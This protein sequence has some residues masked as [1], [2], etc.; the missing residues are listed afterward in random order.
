MHFRKRDA[1]PRFLL[2]ILLLI[3]VSSCAFQRQLATD[4][5]ILRKMDA[6]LRS[7]LSSKRTARQLDRNV[8][9]IVTYSSEVTSEDRLGLRAIC[10]IGTIVGQFATVTIRP[11]RIIQLATIDRVIH[12][13][14][15]SVQDM[16]PIPPPKTGLI[17]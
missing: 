4:P 1:F 17:L 11:R 9:L 6:Q 8:P 15:S 14:L 3:C 10:R 13:T 7:I 2:F 16:Y 12:I 5:Q